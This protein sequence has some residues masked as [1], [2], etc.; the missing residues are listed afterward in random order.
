VY[1][2]GKRSSS[3]ILNVLLN[4]E[5]FSPMRQNTPDPSQISIYCIS[6]KVPVCFLF[7]VKL[8]LFGTD[9]PD[10]QQAGHPDPGV[11]QGLQQKVS[12]VLAKVPF[13]QESKKSS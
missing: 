8:R 12:S 5:I 2:S 6:R 4:E 11:H 9:E 1:L 3:L 7:T 10:D 13:L